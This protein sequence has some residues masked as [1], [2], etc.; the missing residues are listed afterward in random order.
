VFNLT[1][2]EIIFLLLMGLVV[3]GP[4]RLP[5]AMRRVGKAY[6]EFKKMSSGFQTEMRSVLDEPLRELRETADLAKNAAMFDFTAGMNL[7]DADTK[8]ADTKS[9]DDKTGI[10]ASTP[11]EV[12]AVPD[13]AEIAAQQA[14]AAAKRASGPKFGSAAPRPT[15]TTLVAEPVAPG[16]TAEQP[17]PFAPP[18]AN[19][20]APPVSD[21]VVSGFEL[22]A[23]EA[24]VPTE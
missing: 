18:T 19:P 4:D 12:E 3:L 8:S 24:Q 17:Q 14:A 6:G 13:E 2:S 21:A 5:E 7:A 16:L 20:F 15:H 22:P 1:G 23:D 11:I 10:G 9:A